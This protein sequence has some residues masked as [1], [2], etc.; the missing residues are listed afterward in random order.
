MDIRDEEEPRHRGGQ[1][2]GPHQE[3]DFWQINIGHVLTMVI[4]LCGGLMTAS[5]VVYSF[6]ELRVEYSDL[7]SSVDE[8]R[9]WRMQQDADNQTFRATTAGRLDDLKRSVQALQDIIGT[10]TFY[11]REQEPKSNGKGKTSHGG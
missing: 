1:L 2:G 7:K 8:I 10:N 5:G 6:A 4:M 3:S 9:Q 11:Q